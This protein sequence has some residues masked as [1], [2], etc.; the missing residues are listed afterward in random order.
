MKKIQN[1]FLTVIVLI[2]MFSLTGCSLLEETMREDSENNAR[3]TILN[4]ETLKIESPVE[5]KVKIKAI[6]MDDGVESDVTKEMS[7]WRNEETELKAS[8]F[9]TAKYKPTNNSQFVKI[10]E[11]K[12]VTEV[13][14][15]ERVVTIIFAVIV[16]IILFV[17]AV[18]GFIGVYLDFFK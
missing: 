7:V 13:T 1:Y 18:C 17:Y 16:G 15:V 8:D 2:M 11:V 5:G 6:M 12:T 3:V 10:V 9:E 4:K 14:G